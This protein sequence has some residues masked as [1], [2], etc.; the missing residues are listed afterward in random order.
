M[1]RTAYINELVK[2][3]GK[4]TKLEHVLEFVRLGLNEE[5][6]LGHTRVVG[7]AMELRQEW[8]T[9]SHSAPVG[10]RER[11]TNP[12]RYKGYRGRD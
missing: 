2:K 9:A 11:F 8:I 10:K 3:H 12:E 7:L 6:K 1:L 5:A 4:A